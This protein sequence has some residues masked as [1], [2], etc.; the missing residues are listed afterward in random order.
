MKKIINGKKYDTETARIVGTWC[1]GNENDFDY[2]EETL[3]CKKTGEY[4]LYGEGGALTEYC[5]VVGNNTRCAGARIM[6][7]SLEEA[8][9]WGM[10]HLDVDQF[11]AEF[12]EVEE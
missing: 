9:E 1:Y 11:E 6:P 12:G 7:Y 5:V 10:S 4:F 2:I 8:Q 3:Y